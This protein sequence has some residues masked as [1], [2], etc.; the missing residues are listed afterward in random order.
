MQDDILLRRYLLLKS[1]SCAIEDK[2]CR[3]IL[4]RC[5]FRKDNINSYKVLLKTKHI[6][7]IANI[8]DAKSS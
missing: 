1:E 4:K 2:K 3:D 6:K 5:F 7:N 8:I